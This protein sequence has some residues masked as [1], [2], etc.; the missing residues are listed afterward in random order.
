MFLNRLYYKNDKKAIT[1]KESYSRNF[2]KRKDLRQ[3]FSH[4]IQ[5]LFFAWELRPKSFCFIPRRNALHRDSVG[6]VI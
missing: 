4:L 5:V 1:K 2:R 3:T 6:E